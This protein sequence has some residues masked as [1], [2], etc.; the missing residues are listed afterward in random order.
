MKC[1]AEVRT[2]RRQ[3][4]LDKIEIPEDEVAITVELLGKG[5][6]GEVYLADYNGRNAAAKVSFSCERRSRT[7]VSTL[8]MSGYCF[9]SRLL[10]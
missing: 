9:L 10:A 3:R 8:A 1:L 5:G 6:F 2:A 7:S 4:K